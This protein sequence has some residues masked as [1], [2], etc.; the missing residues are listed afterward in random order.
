MVKVLH[1]ANAVPYV[2]CVS[3]VLN[4]SL[5]SILVETPTLTYPDDHVQSRALSPG[6]GRVSFT[7]PILSPSQRAQY[8]Q[9][10]IQYRLAGDAT[11]LTTTVRSDSSSATLPGNLPDGVYEYKITARGPSGILTNVPRMF[12]LRNLGMKALELQ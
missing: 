6:L 8:D 9:F 10:T 12:T 3:L 7:L 5:F 2:V 1:G 11:W 4:P